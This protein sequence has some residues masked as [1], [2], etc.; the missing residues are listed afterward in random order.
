MLEDGKGAYA[1][2]L[3]VK[4]NAAFLSGSTLFTYRN[5]YAIY[6]KSENSSESHDKNASSAS[7]A[8]M[9]FVYFLKDKNQASL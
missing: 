5:F 4:T 9:G 2:A 1:N 8:K 3:T 6:S 7:P